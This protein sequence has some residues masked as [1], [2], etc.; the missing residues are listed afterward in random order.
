MDLMRPILIIS[1]LLSALTLIYT[2][3]WAGSD[4][5]TATEPPAQV[6]SP[7]ASAKTRNTAARQER[8]ASAFRRTNANHHPPPSGQGGI[9]PASARSS[10]RRCG[11][12]GSTASIS[13]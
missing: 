9:R 8:P 3:R 4:P 5:R 11:Q 7:R 13:R 1:I 2:G 12:S 10:C 6:S